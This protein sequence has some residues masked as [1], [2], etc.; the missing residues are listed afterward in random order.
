MTTDPSRVRVSGPLAVH[1]VG[2]GE[3]L[4]RRGYP[5]ERAARHVQ[6]LAHLSRWLEAEGLPAGELTEARVADFLA[7]RRAAGYAEVPTTQTMIRLLGYVAG[8]GVA[9]TMVPAAETVVDAVVEEYRHCLIHERG[10]AAATVRGYVGEARSFLSRLDGPEGLDLSH[11]TAGE[12]NVYVV[13]ECRRRHVGSAKV[14]VT[15]L[16]SLLR[17]LSLEGYTAHPL[18]SAVSCMSPSSRSSPAWRGP[19]VCGLAR[20]SADLACMT[21]GTP[22]PARL[23]S[24]GI[25]PESTWSHSSRCCPRSSAITPS[26]PLSRVAWFSRV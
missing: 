7:A 6:L 20:N 9:P 14:L 24:A 10:L 1:A 21:R 17:F 18:A 19:P 26:A 22:L 16:R 13:G 11:L 4:T 8:L 23:C 3:E 2:F 15:A 12:V 25:G 5:P